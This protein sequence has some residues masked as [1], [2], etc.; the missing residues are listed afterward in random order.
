VSAG[1]P[2]PVLL[3]PGWSERPQFL[4]PLRDRFVEAGWNGADVRAHGFEDP[5]GSNVDHAEELAEALHALRAQAGSEAVDIVA[6]SMGG[7]AVRHLLLHVDPGLV[8][9]AVFL[10]TPHRGTISAYLAWGEGGLE[11]RPRSAFVRSVGAPLPVP[12]L[13]VYSPVDTHVLP[14]WSAVMAGTEKALVWCSHR[15]MVR[16]AGAF[17]RIRAFLEA[18]E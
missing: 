7:L 17:A 10:G 16:H 5:H 18:R 2:T 14:A 15:G 13:D 8:R 4:D 12:V 9:R 6:H 11:M 1:R 3:V